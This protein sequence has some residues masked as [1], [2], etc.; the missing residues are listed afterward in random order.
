MEKAI[1]SGMSASATTIPA[2]KSP[3]T[4]ENHSRRSRCQF[5]DK[6]VFLHR[7]FQR[8]Q[9]RFPPLISIGAATVRIQSLSWM[10]SLEAQTGKHHVYPESKTRVRLWLRA[11]ACNCLKPVFHG[12][13]VRKKC[14]PGSRI[15]CGSRKARRV[16]WDYRGPLEFRLA[17]GRRCFPIWRHATRSQPRGQADRNSR[18]GCR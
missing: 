10:L 9:S 5:I 7:S 1:A 11:K 17:S 15:D 14:R 13:S 18:R 12:H 3:R 8:L 2:S 16:E 6:I 4:F